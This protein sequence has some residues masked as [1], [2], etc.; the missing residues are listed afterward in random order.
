[1]QHSTVYHLPEKYSGADSK[2]LES[3]SCIVERTDQQ[4]PSINELVAHEYPTLPVYCIRPVTIVS[5]C[6]RFIS[7]FK[8][9]VLYA[10]KCNTEPLVLDAI[11]TGGVRQ[12]DCASLKEIKLIRLRFPSANVHFLHPIKSKKD[13]AEAY[14][15]WAVRT[16]ALDSE[17]ELEK[18]I[19]ATTADGNGVAEDLRLLVRLALPDNEHKNYSLYPLSGK[20]GVEGIQPA[21]SLLILARSRARSLGICFHVGSQCTDPDGYAQA[22]AY[23]SEVIAC[24]NVPLE[25]IDVGGGFPTSYPD[26]IPPPLDSYMRIIEQGCQNLPPDLVCNAHIWCEPGRALVSDACSLVI[27]VETRRFN[28]NI[29]HVND[30]IYGN[31]NE[32]GPNRQWQFPVRLIRHSTAELAPFAFFGPTCD[33][34]D[35]M[36]GPFLLPIDIRSDDYIEIGQFGAY[37]TEIRTRFNGFEETLVARVRDAPMLVTPGYDDEEEPTTD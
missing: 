26:S 19:E 2:L 8:G 24:A 37:N 20:F 9:D 33:S 3:D 35:Y 1:M 21:A 15:H 31:L 28:R 6:R 36:P 7:K 30:G 27:R 18:I 32:V 29:L 13:I 34:G 14:T 16:F 22:L 10:V 23:A 5:V 11:W 17:E 25:I 12:F 4:L